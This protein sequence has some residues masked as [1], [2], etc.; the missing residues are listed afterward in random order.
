MEFVFFCLVAAPRNTFS[1]QGLGWVVVYIHICREGRII[2]V[3]WV[4]AALNILFV[5]RMICT[6]Y[7]YLTGLD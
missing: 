2:S 7:P 1:W 3:A 6:L 5:I 4:Q